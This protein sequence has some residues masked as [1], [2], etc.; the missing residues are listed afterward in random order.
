MFIL[1]WSHLT[2]LGYGFK[3]PA[4]FYSGWLNTPSKSQH[5]KQLMRPGSTWQR[6]SESTCTPCWPS[7]TTTRGAIGRHGTKRGVVPEPG[8]WTIHGT[9]WDYDQPLSSIIHGISRK[10]A[11]VSRAIVNHPQFYHFNGWYKP[12]TYGWLLLLPNFIHDCPLLSMILHLSV[13]NYETKNIINRY[14]P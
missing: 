6:A 7:A 2:H 10:S 8:S 5:K 9:S 4:I 3:E 1:R 14:Y 12:S 13:F 11:D